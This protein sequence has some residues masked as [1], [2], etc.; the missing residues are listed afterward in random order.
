M[1]FIVFRK[2]ILSIIILSFLLLFNACQLRDPTKT[3]GINFLENREK[4]LILNETNKNDIVKIL[5]QPH[6]Q[7]IV[8]P[9]TW[10]YFERMTTKGGLHKLGNEVLIVNNILEL[11]FD[12]YGIL[13]E[14]NFYNKEDMKKIKFNTAETTNDITKESFISGILQSLREKM[15]GKNKF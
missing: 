5:G 9:N 12:K 2:H 15:Y 8:S 3:H 10:V 1:I 6:V 13:T 14:K 11:E 7:S 4:Q